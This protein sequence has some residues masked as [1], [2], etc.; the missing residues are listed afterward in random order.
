MFATRVN[1]RLV[2][3]RLDADH[4]QPEWLDHEARV[5]ADGMA[6]VALDALREPGTSITYGIVQP[7]EFLLPGNGV[8]LIRCTDIHDLRVEAVQLLWVSHAIER[9]YA[10][11]RVKPGDVLIGIAGTLGV[12][13]I[14]PDG[15][16]PANLNQSV[17]RVRCTNRETGRW[18]G[19]FLDCKYGQ[20]VLRRRAVGGVQ[21]H[22]NLDD[23]PAVPVP[24]PHADARAYVASKVYHAETL[25]ARAQ[26]LEAGFKHAVGLPVMRPSKPARF[27]RIDAAAIR[28]DLN[29]GRYDPDRLAVQDAL[30][31]HGGVELSTFA[32]V[33]TPT[34]DPK[35]PSQR[36]LG[37]DGISS[38]CAD[39]A[40]T[41]VEAAGV[42]GTCRALRPGPAISKLRPYL[43]KVALIPGELA[44]ALG[45]TELLCVDS[46]GVHP[47][48]VYGALKLD[49]TMRQL[50][51]VA[52]GATHPRV[53]AEDVLEVL[54][55]MHDDHETLGQMLE[56]AQRAYGATRQLTTAARLIVEALI[57]RKVTEAELIAAHKDLGADRALLQRLTTQGL[58]AR[59]GD[60]LFPDLDCLE[61]LLANASAGNSA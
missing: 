59:T 21:Q 4:Y 45:S 9:P 22:L 46:N 23:L 56:T 16:E 50:D 60:R 3:E 38:I 55:L 32:R 2:S 7:G 14:A 48:F 58:D 19:A 27:T 34:A 24:M 33:L 8:R 37:L 49:T 5:R 57:E 10:R 1:P 20:S 47:G 52:T 61:E 6:A 43:N 44:G 29:P 30:R 42:T 53:T 17:A 13:G 41:T 31:A 28:A 39:L 26:A 25:R 40:M 54:V 18:V 11:A 36:Y 35:S 15:I 51:P 12:I